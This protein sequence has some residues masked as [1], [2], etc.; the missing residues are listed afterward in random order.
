[1]GKLS[2]A[3]LSTFFKSATKP[4]HPTAER[5]EEEKKQLKA[6][7]VYT[8]AAINRLILRR[9]SSK[10]V[11][12]VINSSDEL[13]TAGLNP[14]QIMKIAFGEGGYNNILAL[15]DLI[16][17]G[18]KQALV[19]GNQ[20]QV[21]DLVD[22][23]PVTC[24]KKAL[25]Y[26]LKTLHL[27]SIE[28]AIKGLSKSGGSKKLKIILTLAEEIK[29]AGHQL[30]DIFSQPNL[31]FKISLKKYGIKII[32]KEISL[33]FQGQNNDDLSPEL[34]T[35]LQAATDEE[36][37]YTPFMNENMTDPQCS[38]SILNHSIGTK[39]TEPFLSAEQEYRRLLQKHMGDTLPP[40]DGVLDL[41]DEPLSSSSEIQSEAIPMA[42]APQR[43]FNKRGRNNADATTPAK[44]P[45][46]SIPI[47]PEDA[48]YASFRR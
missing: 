47:T 7:G 2:A 30:K 14:A 33:F 45:R 26:T 32:Q 3:Q 1:M 17:W 18:E 12:E 11:K 28:D 38:N 29:R 44:A 5:Y 41:F 4:N 6:L 24:K 15:K 46:I 27:S 31:F 21:Q 37:D 43:I 19:D 16:S 40:D 9:S 20:A 48:N 10:C 23:N 39:F 13:I 35:S 8:E 25:A 34:L 22:G 36:I 42:Q